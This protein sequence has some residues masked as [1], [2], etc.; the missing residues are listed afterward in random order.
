M[1]FSLGPNPRAEQGLRALVDEEGRQDEGVLRPN[2]DD[3]KIE[4]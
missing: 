4:T 2:I 1:S 3:A